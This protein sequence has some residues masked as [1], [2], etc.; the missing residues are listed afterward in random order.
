VVTIDK[1]GSLKGRDA[2]RNLR[3]DGRDACWSS[4]KS[5]RLSNPTPHPPRIRSSPSPSPSRCL[6]F[7]FDKLVSSRQTP[8]PMATTA[9]EGLPSSTEQL[10][11]ASAKRTREI[12]AAD[13]ASSAA[14]DHAPNSA[15]SIPAPEPA[16]SAAA[17]Q[18]NVAARIRNEY[19]HVRELPP[20]L[21]AKMAA[22]A[23]TAA[24]KRKKIRS[25]NAEEQASD[26]KMRKMIAGA[27]E[28]ADK[29]KDAQS[30]AL[31]LRAGGKGAAPNAQG[32]TP[33]RNTPSSALVRKDTVRQTKPEWHQPWKVSRVM[34]GHMGWVRSIATDPDN[35][36]FATGAADRTIKIWDLASG[37][38]KLTLT[39]HISAVRGLEV[40]PRHPYLF[41][42]GEDKMVKCWDLE[43]NKVIRHYHGHLSGVYTLALHP[44]LDVLITGGRDGVARV[45]VSLL[46]YQLHC[47]A[48]NETGYANTNKRAR[49]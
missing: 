11:R 29:A 4:I 18:V 6:R 7:P 30:M 21:A 8:L 43:T 45:W 33:N 46:Q 2:L 40:S 36:W 27:S 32:P 34:S 5:L 24:E 13:F 17:D 39:G 15:F 1:A 20:A 3:G 26:A 9:S 23:T 37:Q 35:Q 12:F 28:K 49:A 41:S 38:L 25:Q 48:D 42:C 44:T 16:P 31:T 47:F 19:E 22:A 14:L 10:V